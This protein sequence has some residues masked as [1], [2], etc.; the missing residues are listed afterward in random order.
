MPKKPQWWPWPTW[1]AWLAARQA[2]P[3]LCINLPDGSGCRPL[4][5]GSIGANLE[6]KEHKEVSPIN[7]G[8]HLYR[9]VHKERAARRLPPSRALLVEADPSNLAKVRTGFTALLGQNASFFDGAV[10]L[11]CGGALHKVMGGGLQNISCCP[12]QSQQL[13][14][15]TPRHQGPAFATGVG[16]LASAEDDALVKQYETRQKHDPKGTVKVGQY[17]YHLKTIPCIDAGLLFTERNFTE[18]DAL[19]VHA[20][21]HVATRIGAMLLL[22]RREGGGAS[23]SDV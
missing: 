7:C 8:D 23:A 10:S 20:P 5:L 3:R 22:E 16:K 17:N 15:W 12:R 9:F 1:L 13:S 19:Q 21:C 18:L 14:F 4:T 2:D 6:C 11:P